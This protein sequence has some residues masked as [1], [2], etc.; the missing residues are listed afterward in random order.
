VIVG[1]VA[2]ASEDGEELGAGLVEPAAFADGL[3]PAVEFEGPGAVA[4][5][6]EPPVPCGCIA[7]VG[8]RR[9]RRH[10]AFSCRANRRVSATFGESFAGAGHC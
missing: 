4:V 8:G 2:L 5:A 7:M 9:A 6:E 3:E 1:V 10:L